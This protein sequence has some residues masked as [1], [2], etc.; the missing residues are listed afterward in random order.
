MAFLKA[1]YGGPMVDARPLVRNAANTGW[2]QANAF[3][4]NA[5]NTGWTLVASAVLSVTGPSE[6]YGENAIGTG[7]SGPSETDLYTLQIRGGADSVQ[8]A[9]LT[10]D[11]SIVATSPNSHATTFY[12][13]SARAAGIRATFRATV[14]RG[15]Q[16]AHHDVAVTL[17]YG[18]PI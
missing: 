5:A 17:F 7:L 6:W 15:G 11:S 12:S 3:V 16:T 9:R 14:T 13:S 1:S 8:W 10:G 18:P 2:Q 4:R